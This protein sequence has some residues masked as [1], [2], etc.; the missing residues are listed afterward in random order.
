MGASASRDDLAAHMGRVADQLVSAAEAGNSMAMHDGI[1]WSRAVARVAGPRRIGSADGL[2]VLPFVEQQMRLRSQFSSL[3]D[4][5]VGQF[6]DLTVSAR[7]VWQDSRLQFAAVEKGV[8]A[9]PTFHEYAAR[10][11]RAKPREAIGEDR[12]G[13]EVGK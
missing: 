7:Q 3:L 1:K 6:A 2:A 10:L 12:I 4:G 5:S 9:V 13:P 8:H 11:A